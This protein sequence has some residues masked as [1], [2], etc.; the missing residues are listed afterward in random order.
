M[1]RVLVP[2]SRKIRI[3]ASIINYV[4][5]LLFFIV[6]GR[7]GEFNSWDMVVFL[8]TLIF[9][10]TQLILYFTK[11]QTVGKMICKLHIYTYDQQKAKAD[12]LFLRLLL[13]PFLSMFFPYMFANYG[14]ILSKDKQCLHD[15]FTKTYVGIWRNEFELAIKT[16]AEMMAARRK[17]AL[18]IDILIPVFITAIMLGLYF[19]IILLWIALGIITVGYTFFMDWPF[20]NNLPRYLIISGVAITV[21]IYIVEAILISTRRTTIGNMIIKVK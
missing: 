16:P 3:F 14:F 13:G 8:F 9:L 19:I 6:A 21:I 10:I 15:K 7:G 20:I 4:P 17:A 1:N 12:K 2:A 18:A 11:G 5:I